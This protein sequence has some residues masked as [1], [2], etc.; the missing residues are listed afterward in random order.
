LKIRSSMSLPS[1][2]LEHVRPKAI[3]EMSIRL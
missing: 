2:I 3:G 1:D